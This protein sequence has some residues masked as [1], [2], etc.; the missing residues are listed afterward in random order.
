MAIYYIDNLKQ[1]MIELLKDKWDIYIYTYIH[2]FTYIYIYLHIYT[3]IY[4]IIG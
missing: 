1:Y 4:F 3:Y 2:T